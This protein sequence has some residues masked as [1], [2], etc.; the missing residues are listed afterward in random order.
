MPS[1]HVQTTSLPSADLDLILTFRFRTN[2]AQCNSRHVSFRMRDTHHRLCG[3]FSDPLGR[4]TAHGET[5]LSHTV[6]G[7]CLD[8]A[9][10]RMLC[11]VLCELDFPNWSKCATRCQ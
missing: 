8:A 9:V 11:S 10:G 6:L 5:L 7:W 2:S 1:R 3:H 4:Y